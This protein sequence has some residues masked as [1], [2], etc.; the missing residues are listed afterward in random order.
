MKTER[1]VH[2]IRLGNGLIRLINQHLHLSSLALI[3]WGFCFSCIHST[4]PHSSSNWITT[5]IGE[6]IH[7]GWVSHVYYIHPLKPSN[8]NSG[9]LLCTRWDC[10]RTLSDMFCLS[11]MFYDQFHKQVILEAY[12]WERFTIQ[13]MIHSYKEKKPPPSFQHLWKIYKR[14]RIHSCKRYCLTLLEDFRLIEK[15]LKLLSDVYPFC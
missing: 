14:R 12:L 1:E 3:L 9:N 11:N 2:L 13:N 15:A 10:N 4:I 6:T 7:Y 8:V 5:S